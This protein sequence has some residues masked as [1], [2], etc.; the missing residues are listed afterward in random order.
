MVGNLLNVDPDLAA[1]V[2]NGLGM[3][4]SPA[5][6]IQKNMKTTIEGRRIGIL[7]ADGTDAKALQALV[8]AIENAKAT[9]F[10]VAPKVGKAKLSDGTVMKADGQLAGSPSQL[11]DAAAVLLSKEGTAML[12]KEAAAILWVMDAYGHL[13]AIGHTAD[14]AP[15]LQKAGVEPDAGVVALDKG[16]LEAAARRYWDREPKLRTL[17]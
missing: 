16:F 4:A 7:I 6:S 9:P 17:A 15:L 11:F 13:K 14:S 10:I 3:D 12:L 8:T 2:A 5:L 1:R